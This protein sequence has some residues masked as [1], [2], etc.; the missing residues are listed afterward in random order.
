[1]QKSHITGFQVYIILIRTDKVS[2]LINFLRSDDMSQ[3]V[4]NVAVSAEGQKALDDAFEMAK[5]LQEEAIKSMPKQNTRSKVQTGFLIGGCII[6]GAILGAL[7]VRLYDNVRAGN[8][9]SIKDLG[10]LKKAD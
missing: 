10:S 7:G 3:D 6:G 9:K 8:I 5:R 2:V 4:N 1:M